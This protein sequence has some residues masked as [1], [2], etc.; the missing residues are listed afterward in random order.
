MLRF[1][2]LRCRAIVAGVCLVPFAAAQG[3]AAEQA[4]DREQSRFNSSEFRAPDGF[5][6]YAWKT[7]LGKVSRLEPEPV[8]VNVAYAA[9]K[10]VHFDGE[11]FNSFVAPG[12]VV[13]INS[14]NMTGMLA[15]R[16]VQGDGYYALA[17]YFVDSQGFRIRDESGGKVVL[18]P[19]TYQFCAQWN[20]ISNNLKGDPLEE[21]RL[22]GGRLHFRSE[23]AAQAQA[24][25]D[26]THRTSYGRVLKWLISS[27]GPPE[28]FDP[29]GVVLVPGWS[30]EELRKM[31]AKLRHKTEYWCRPIGKALVPSC[32]TSIVLSFDAT[33]GQGQVIFLTP[34]VW[35]YAHARQ[36]GSA[37]GDPLYRVLHGGFRQPKIQYQCVDSFLCK[38]P[39]PKPMPEAM[40]ARFRIPAKTQ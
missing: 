18:F 35:I 39:K 31:P 30:E 6:G 19:V 4:P 36:F 20:G 13:G 21:M 2:K 16:E 12:G 38:P 23:T 37:E 33:T 25:V 34:P 3:Q 14:D 28:G 29:D 10:V 1:G 32:A 27:Y 26:H 24:M 40:L 11:C 7:A 22:C 5:G 8:Y 9:G 17:E 15:C